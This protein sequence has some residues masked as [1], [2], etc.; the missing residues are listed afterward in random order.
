MAFGD[1][2]PGVGRLG[3]GSLGGEPDVYEEFDSA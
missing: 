3:A 2:L 1:E